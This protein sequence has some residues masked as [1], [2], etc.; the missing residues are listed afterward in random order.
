MPNG[1]STLST[2]RFVSPL[3]QALLASPRIPFSSRYLVKK[4]V[5][6]PTPKDIRASLAGLRTYSDPPVAQ[7]RP[8]GPEPEDNH[9][10]PEPEDYINFWEP[11]RREGLFK[12]KPAGGSWI[13]KSDRGFNVI[14]VVHKHEM[15]C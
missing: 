1:K 8:L 2:A 6:G 15:L 4:H 14:F 12:G 5:K 13:N 9:Q 7:P 3:R 10:P 11:I